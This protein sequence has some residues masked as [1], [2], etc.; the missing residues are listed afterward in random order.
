MQNGLVHPHQRQ[1]ARGA[2]LLNHLFLF[3][4]FLPGGLGAAVSGRQVVRDVVG[5]LLQG[6]GRQVLQVAQAGVCQVSAGIRSILLQPTSLI[7]EGGK[8]KK[9]HT[10]FKITINDQCTH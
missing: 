10:K 7:L 1:D 3:L 6:G 2:L 4:L 9:I 5:V 8:R